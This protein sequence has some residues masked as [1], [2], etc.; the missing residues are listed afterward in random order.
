MQNAC[1]SCWLAGACKSAFS[2]RHEVAGL[3]KALA[4]ALANALAKALPR[5]QG[6]GH[7]PGQGRGQSLGQ[8][9]GQGLGQRPCQRLSQGPGQGPCQSLA[10]GPGQGPGSGSWPGPWP[11]SWPKPFPEPWRL[12]RQDLPVALVEAGAIRAA[13]GI[14]TRFIPD[15]WSCTCLLLVGVCPAID[16][17]FSQQSIQSTQF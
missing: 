14:M 10:Q 7:G 8:G 1:R 17:S 2:G 6:L 12:A 11:R 9:P 16:T 15:A 5:V 13:A 3:A 4:K